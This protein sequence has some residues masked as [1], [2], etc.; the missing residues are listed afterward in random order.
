MYGCAFFALKHR[1]LHTNRLCR[2]KLSLSLCLSQCA[3][4]CVYANH[5]SPPLPFSSGSSILFYRI[6]SNHILLDQNWD[7]TKCLDC[8][9]STSFLAM[10][11]YK[12]ESTVANMR[13]E[14][15]YPT[16][17]QWSYSRA[18]SIACVCMIH[19]CVALI[20]SMARWLC[21][22]YVG[23]LFS[24]LFFLKMLFLG[25]QTVDGASHRIVVCVTNESVCVCDILYIS[26]SMVIDTMRWK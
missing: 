20:R 26:C 22:F 1:A 14:Y 8:L 24:K 19:I 21:D 15:L 18:I 17:S 16:W 13:A 7:Q 4:V 10:P 23:W 25:D 3:H 5:A 6:V 12:K 2:S 11:G 9:F